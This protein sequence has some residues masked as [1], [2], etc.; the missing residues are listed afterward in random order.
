MLAYTFHP[1]HLALGGTSRHSQWGNLACFSPFFPYDQP[2]RYPWS[3]TPGAPL[4]KEGLKQ[5]RAQKRRYWGGE[6]VLHSPRSSP[7]LLAVVGVR[8]RSQSKGEREKSQ[9][10]QLLEWGTDTEPPPQ[11]SARTQNT[12]GL[13]SIASTPSPLLTCCLPLLLQNKQHREE[14]HLGT[15][16]SRGLHAQSPTQEGSSPPHGCQMH[17]AI[18]TQYPWGLLGYL[19]P[20]SDMRATG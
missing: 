20:R 3:L 9:L 19:D 16:P 6:V 18:D 11:P 15:A 5:N 1:T 8:G 13:S 7:A 12:A 14:I 4:F 17:L 2:Q 10:E